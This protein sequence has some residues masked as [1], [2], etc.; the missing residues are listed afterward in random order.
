MGRYKQQQ[1]GGKG[2]KILFG[3]LV[4]FLSL[5]LAIWITGNS[6]LYKTLLYAYPNIDDLGIFETRIISNNVPQEWPVS[7]DYNKKNLPEKTA[8]ELI[9]NESV[10]FLVIRNDSICYEQY[11]DHYEPS[12]LSNSFSVAKSIVGI[13]TGIASD[14]GLLRLDDPVNMYIPEYRDGDNVKL[15]IRHLLSMSSG[16]DWDESY[17]SLFSRTTEAY[18]GTQL[19]KLAASLKVVK[20]PGK[21]WD[22]QSCNTLLLGMVLEN[23]T[24]KKLSDYAAEK[25]WTPIGSAHSAY[26]SLDHADGMEKAYCCFY[27]DARDFARIG[28]LMLDSGNWHGNQLVSSALVKELL[29]PGRLTNDSGVTVDYY[30]LHWWLYNK[31]DHPLFYARGI[32]GQYIIVIPDQRL[33]IVRLGKKRGEKL[34]SNHYS[35]MMTYVEGVLR[36]FGK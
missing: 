23:A 9:K 4:I 34:S 28:Q 10:A 30:G 22:Y 32:L 27:A 3:F 33:V 21:T 14:E 11:W 6:Y 15:T 35:D 17:N 20:E 19:K 25:L 36:V 12:S 18:Y 13:L 8:D 24:G 2:K 16:L 29:T 1:E 5:N 26:W 31:G 7:P